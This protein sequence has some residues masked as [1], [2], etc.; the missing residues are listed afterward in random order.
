MLELCRRTFGEDHPETLKA[1]YN[2]G[3]A[4]ERLGRLDE[5]EPLFR[6]TLDGRRRVLG[7]LHPHTIGTIAELIRLLRKLERYD[8]AI[9]EM[10]RVYHTVLDQPEPRQDLAHSAASLIADTCDDAGRTDD[11]A[12]W[13]AV[14]Q[15]HETP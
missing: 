15:Q 5:V 6:A 10:T 8:D 2:L 14:A 9:N 4:R 3:L 7:E 12:H 11:A 13:R 1:Y